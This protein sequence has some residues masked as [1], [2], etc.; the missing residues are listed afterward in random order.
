MSWFREMPE[1]GT[2]GFGL[3]FKGRPMSHDRGT[4][5]TV[6]VLACI[7]IMSVSTGCRRSPFQR[8]VDNSVAAPVLARDSEPVLETVPGAV[9]AMAPT[10]QRPTGPSRVAGFPD[11]LPAPTPLL[12]AALKRAEAQEMMQR[13]ALRASHSPPSS[14]SQPIMQRASIVGPSKEPAVSAQPAPRPA[15]K[16]KVPEVASS[17]PKA[18]KAE[19]VDPAVSWVKALDRLKQV[20]HESASQP[21]TEDG[22]S[23][24][25]LRAQ[26]VE[27]LA[28]EKVNPA[29]VALLKGAVTALAGAAST[30]A[31]DAKSDPTRSGEIRSAVLALEDRVP[32]GITELRL[33]RKVLGFGAFEPLDCS[34]LKAGQAVLIYC[35]LTGLRYH[36]HDA[37]YVSR[38]SSR[39]ELVRA[40]DGTRV[41]E[42][43][44]GE[45]EDQCRSKRRD[46]YVNYRINLPRA[47]SP[48]DYR[49][50]LTQ[51][52]LLAQQSTSCEL[53]LTVIR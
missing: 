34:G 7:A 40:K 21:G 35:E 29:S 20:A 3:E 48:G 27:W 36:S 44:L 47:V 15:E 1:R 38:L 32:L 8:L 53:P 18:K 25:E 22:V 31:K 50:R 43:P 5:R 19:P 42:Q 11:P 13:E 26:V 41:W 39:V 23:V 46:F 17:A 10:P 51:T 33:C 28:S 45:A 24:W 14:T 12:D 2:A 49:L 4:R 6:R 52:D 16:T 9:T 37:S 30:P